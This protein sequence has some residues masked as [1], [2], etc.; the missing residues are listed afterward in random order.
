M[1]VFCDHFSSTGGMQK[2]QT[3]GAEDCL[4]PVLKEKD[5]L[6]LVRISG[7]NVDNG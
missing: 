6:C 1:K 4:I 5:M 7:Q 3:K 2:L